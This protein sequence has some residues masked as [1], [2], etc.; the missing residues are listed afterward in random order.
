MQDLILLELW[1]SKRL[2]MS[3]C[4]YFRFEELKQ[5]LVN[6]AQVL[7]TLLDYRLFYFWLRISFREK[8]KTLKLFK[9][10]H[11][12]QSGKN[13][14]GLKQL[15]VHISQQYNPLLF[16]KWKRKKDCKQ[17]QEKGLMKRTLYCAREERLRFVYIVTIPGNRTSFVCEQVSL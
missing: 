12:F 3:W 11:S 8:K 13:L 1:L 6:F 5:Y 10:H 17:F 15:F 14:L 9:K 4:C 16:R 7:F 2:G